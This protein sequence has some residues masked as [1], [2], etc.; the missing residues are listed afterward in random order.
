M[1]AGFFLQ[2][3]DR[4]EQ[5]FRSGVD[6]GSQ[7]RA[8][9]VRLAL[10]QLRKFAATVRLADNSTFLYRWLPN[11]NGVFFLASF[12]L[13]ALKGLRSLLPTGAELRHSRIQILKLPQ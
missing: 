5:V 13:R 7:R 3:A 8:P 10:H 6:I 1:H 11:V 9:V 4:A 12:L 2:R